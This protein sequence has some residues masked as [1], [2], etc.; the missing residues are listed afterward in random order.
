MVL[1]QCVGDVCNVSGTD[2]MLNIYNIRVVGYMWLCKAVKG[3]PKRI[4]KRVLE[5]HYLLR[6]C[7]FLVAIN[8]VIFAGFS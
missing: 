5:V 1:L 8:N 2:N 6:S 7:V 3:I 4:V